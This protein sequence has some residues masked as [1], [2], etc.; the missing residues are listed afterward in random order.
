MHPS[1][2]PTVAVHLRGR[3]KWR[4]ENYVD[5]AVLDSHARNRKEG[6]YSY[7]QASKIFRHLR[8]RNIPQVRQ[9]TRDAHFARR[10]YRYLKEN[11][12]GNAS[13]L[14]YRLVFKRLLPEAYT[15]TVGVHK[16]H[17]LTF[18][19]FVRKLR[20]LHWKMTSIADPSTGKY[21]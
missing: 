13:L 18:A 1:M 16:S 3:S 6:T 21:M 2:K 10:M 17:F 9:E 14:G 8:P 5:N 19:A 12:K 20:N 11:A 4:E 7:G 15:L